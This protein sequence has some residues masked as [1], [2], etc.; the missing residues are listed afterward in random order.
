[1]STS[2]SRLRSYYRCRQFNNSGKFAPKAFAR[3]VREDETLSHCYQYDFLPYV[4]SLYSLRPGFRRKHLPV[5][6]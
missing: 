4:V 1:M 2:W 3:K 5:S 6:V